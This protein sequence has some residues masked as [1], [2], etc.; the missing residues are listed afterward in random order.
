MENRNRQVED[1][2]HIELFRQLKNLPTGQGPAGDQKALASLPDEE[3]DEGGGAF[4][5]SP[6]GGDCPAKDARV[7]G[8]PAVWQ[9]PWK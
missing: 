3:T 1:P 4:E 6:E 8:Q 5:N 9:Q 2:R 7:A